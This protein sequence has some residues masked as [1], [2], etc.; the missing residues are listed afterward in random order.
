MGARLIAT[1]ALLLACGL[2]SSCGTTTIYTTDPG[3]RVIAEGRTLGRG[4]GQLSRRGFPGSTTVVVRTD[5]GRQAEAVVRREFTGIT[6]LMGLFTYGV[7]LVACWEYPDT[8]FVPLSGVAAPTYQGTPAAVD[9][10]LQPPPG[11]QAPAQQSN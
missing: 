5:D 1:V 10:W 8:V 3:A 7:C 4:Q 2:A 9:P 11:W 6:L